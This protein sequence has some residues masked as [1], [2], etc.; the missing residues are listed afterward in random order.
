MGLACALGVGGV[1]RSGIK[2]A[3]SCGGQSGRHAREGVAPRVVV[4][5]HAGGHHR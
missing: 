2:V 1:Q 4:L 5:L 3:G